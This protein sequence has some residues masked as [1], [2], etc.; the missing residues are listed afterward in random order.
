MKKLL[1]LAFIIT[2]SIPFLLYQLT[3]FI[4]KTTYTDIFSEFEIIL[5]LLGFTITNAI[6]I[7]CTIYV[8]KRMSLIKSELEGR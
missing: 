5:F 2:F 1:S 8:L 6:T 4:T 7:F 3:A